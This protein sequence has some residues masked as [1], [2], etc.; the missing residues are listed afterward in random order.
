VDGTD[1]PQF[2]SRRGF[3]LAGAT[4]V[5]AA[6]AYGVT[7]LLQHKSKDTVTASAVPAARTS[8]E[9]T[10]PRTAT[11]YLAQSSLPPVATLARYDLV[12]I[13]NEWPHRVPPDYFVKL[14]A[15]NPRMRLLAYVDVVDSMSSIGSAKFWPDSYALWQFKTPTSS[16]LPRAWLARTAAGVPVHD[17]L[18]LVM[19]NLTDV[20]PVVGGQRFVE[21]AADWVTGRVWS[22]GI[23]DGIYLDVWGDTL[24]TVDQNKWDI[25]GTGHDIPSAKI[26]GPGNPLDRGLTSGERTMRSRMPDAVLV[27][28]GTR[29][30]HDG[31]LDGLVWE[32]FADSLVHRD[33]V[34]DLTQYVTVSGSAP[35]RKPGASVTISSRRVQAGSADDYRRAR[36]ALTATLMQNGFWAP[37]GDDYGQPTYYDEMDGAG[38]GRG[39]LGQALQPDPPLS[40]ITAVTD[41]GTGSPAP[42]VYRRDFEHGIALVNVGPTAQQ[43]T[44][45]RAYRHLSGKADRLV[46]NGTTVE[47]LT[48][49]AQDGVIL[50]D[51]LSPP[52]PAA[53]PR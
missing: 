45:R 8:S 17:Y 13:N 7:D 50:L 19:T 6:A 42:Y 33:P 40:V 29:T 23:W 14:R 41:G 10:F 43:V 34:S 44:F 39:Y 16:R 31:L 21:Y 37:M 38:L 46:N 1:R 3:L 2:T 30:V 47:L 36:F 49:P 48:I 26:Y 15:A 4:A 52:S 22:A 53:S 11:C 9:I 18:D 28:N 35:H 32:S 12:V 25:T 20:C 51:P 5:A 27:A 24:W